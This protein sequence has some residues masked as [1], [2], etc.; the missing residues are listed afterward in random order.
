MCYHVAKIQRFMCKMK[1]KQ[2]NKSITNPIIIKLSPIP[3][4]AAQESATITS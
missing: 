2:E 1:I 4:P 3:T